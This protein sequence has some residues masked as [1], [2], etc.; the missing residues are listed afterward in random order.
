MVPWL[1]YISWSIALKNFWVNSALYCFHYTVF[2]GHE[3]SINNKRAK[4]NYSKMAHC[5][6][7]EF[8]FAYFKSCSYNDFYISTK[9]TWEFLEWY[10]SWSAS[11]WEKSHRRSFDIEIFSFLYEPNQR[12]VKKLR[13][14][15]KSLQLSYEI[16][17]K[18]QFSD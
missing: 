14:N 8:I 9:I 10:F 16:L 18:K 11:N 5:G 17:K 2:Q 4:D 12:Q 7:I 1:V 6:K 15:I 13:R 3:S